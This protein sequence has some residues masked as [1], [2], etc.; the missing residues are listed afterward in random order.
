[1]G[2]RVSFVQG[3][4]VIVMDRLLHPTTRSMTSLP[5][6]CHH[7]SML[8][9]YSTKKRCRL[10][11]VFVCRDCSEKLMIEGDRMTLKGI[12][13]NTDKPITASVCLGCYVE[14]FSSY[15]VGFVDLAPVKLSKTPRSAS[16]IVGTILE[17]VPHPPPGRLPLPS[18]LPP[19][20]KRICMPIFLR[21]VKYSVSR[22]SEVTTTAIQR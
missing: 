21:D 1:M 16:M 18:P 7:C 2:R 9:H 5:L 14:K 10:C 19:L 4:D 17:I 8:F 15:V 6:A 12:Y 22:P 20:Q 13:R 11:G 3:I